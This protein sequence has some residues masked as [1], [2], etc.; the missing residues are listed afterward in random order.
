MYTVST[1][2]QKQPLLEAG[3]VLST[4]KRS[5]SRKHRSHCKA[6]SE[7]SVDSSGFSGDVPMAL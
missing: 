1:K 7:G 4:W 5:L 6:L 3:L 2:G